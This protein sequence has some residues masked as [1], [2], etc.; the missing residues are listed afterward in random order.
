MLA[1]WRNTIRREKRYALKNIEIGNL[2]MNSRPKSIKKRHVYCR[3]TTF[4][5]LL[6]VSS[7]SSLQ[8]PICSNA[9]VGSCFFINK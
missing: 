2:T 4:F 3:L 8:L 9:L 7:I 6:F 5:P 1:G